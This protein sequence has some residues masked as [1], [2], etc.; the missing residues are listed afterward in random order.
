MHTDIDLNSLLLVQALA[1]S[2]SFTAAAERLGCSKT[3]ISLQLKTL[4]QR[5]GVALFRR[6]TRQLNLT[7]AGQYMLEHC[8][9]LLE[10]L[11]AQLQQLQHDDSLLSGKIVI[12]APEDYSTQILVP[13]LIRFQ[14]LHADLT[15]ELRSSDHVRD[16]ISEGI[17]LSIRIGWLQD[18]SH[19]AVPLGKFEQWLM[20]A[21]DYFADKAKPSTPDDLTAYDFIAFSQLKSPLHWSF[22]KAQQLQQV[23]FKAKFTSSS[24][25]TVSAFLRAG[26]G[27]GVLTNY[28]ARP[29]I[30]RNELQQV[31]PQWSLPA[32]G[33]YAVYPPGNKR[34][35]KTRALV[36]YL[37]QALSETV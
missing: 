35:A 27:I 15:I 16:M 17:D 29:L 2:G 13:V 25:Q 9:P 32:G 28:S 5:L 26:A 18:S 4:E 24:T 36:A 34:P 23:Q 6:T 8:M 1:Q 20:A 37:R 11:S 33:I 21:P 7:E 30:S 31:L 22:S 3:K 14:Q 12:S 19:I 10:Q